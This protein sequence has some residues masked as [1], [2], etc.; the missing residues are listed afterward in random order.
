MR[1]AA[2]G[3][4][5]RQP[6]P[7][8]RTVQDRVRPRPHAWFWADRGSECPSAQPE[9]QPMLLDHDRLSQPPLL[10]RGFHDETMHPLGAVGAAWDRT[11]LLC[12]MGNSAAARPTARY[13]MCE[14]DDHK[15]QSTIQAG[16]PS[17]ICR[18]HSPPPVSLASLEWRDT[19][20]LPRLEREK[21]DQPCLSRFDWAEGC[22]ESR[23]ILRVSSSARQWWV[24]DVARCHG[25]APHCRDSR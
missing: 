23:E 19:A 13:M 9:V 3:W 22:S 6:P 24:S 5:G 21:A 10:A 4:G 2:H 16:A 11:R 17:N 7:A 20:G 25:H 15:P 12:T 18:W 1:L 14:S 8:R